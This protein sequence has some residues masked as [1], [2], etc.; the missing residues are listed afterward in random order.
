MLHQLPLCS[1]GSA[2]LSTLHGLFRVCLIKRLGAARSS[3]NSLH[4]EGCLSLGSICSNFPIFVCSRDFTY[5]SRFSDSPSVSLNMAFL[6]EGGCFPKHSW[7]HSDV[8][9]FP[10]FHMCF[11]ILFAP[12][13]SL[14][15]LNLFAFFVGGK[16]SIPPPPQDFLISL[17]MHKLPV[18]NLATSLSLLNFIRTEQ[19]GFL[20]DSGRENTA[21]RDQSDVSLVFIQ[22]GKT[23]ANVAIRDQAGG[24][25]NGGWAPKY[26]QNRFYLYSTA[27]TLKKEV[28]IVSVVVLPYAFCVLSPMHSW[29]LSP[30]RPEVL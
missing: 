2:L 15:F 1:G 8:T 22:R 28:L 27:P 4:T 29:P 14:L 13:V 24:S 30:C 10:H 9:I 7:H 25:R 21:S 18:A 11:L 16:S 3:V 23:P 17:F 5:P 19:V 26:T 12:P 20:L 6:A